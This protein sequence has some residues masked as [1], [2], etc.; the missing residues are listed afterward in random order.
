MVWTYSDFHSAIESAIKVYVGASLV[1]GDRVG[2]RLENSFDAY[3]Y[4]FGALSMG[5][6]YVPLAP[7]DPMTRVQTIIADS[8]LRLVI[9]VDTPALIR[10]LDSNRKP[11]R[12]LPTAGSHD[13]AVYIMHTSGTTGTPKGIL[14]SESNLCNFFEWAHT[15]FQ[16][17]ET[18]V[19]LGHINLTFDLSAFHLFLPFL[20]GASVRIT[21]PNLERIAPG[22]Q[23]KNGVTIALLVPRMTDLLAAAGF[24]GLVRRSVEIL[25][26]SGLNFM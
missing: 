14:I 15:Y 6:T 20:A 11:I 8:D 2:I 19:F 5:L 13:Q 1:P 12:P 21:P 17:S 24:L 7:S 26:S 23:F 3:A 10:D 25:R 9:D 4:I 16:V 18:D 22:E